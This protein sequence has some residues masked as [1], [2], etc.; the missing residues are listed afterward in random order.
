M[1]YFLCVAVLTIGFLI[2]IGA[3]TI[4]NGNRSSY[5]GGGAAPPVG[6]V[7]FDSC[8]NAYDGTYNLWT[9]NRPYIAEKF[10]A[11]K[12][13]TVTAIDLSIQIVDAGSDTVQFAIFDDNS[14]SPGNL[15]GSWSPYDGTAILSSTASSTFIKRSGQNASITNTVTY[16][17]VAWQRKKESATIRL[18]RCDDCTTEV[19]KASLADLSWATSLSTSRSL[20][21]RLYE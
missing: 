9:T 14:G 13:T 15:V 21:W 2:F 5:W 7:L 3:Q 12:T 11:T 16:W 20:R 1:R 18:E 4:L 17:V 19:I 6:E 8:A 10:V